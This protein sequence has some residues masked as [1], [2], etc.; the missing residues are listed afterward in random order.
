MELSSSFLF[1]PKPC[2]C[3]PPNYS[4]SPLIRNR[5][6]NF[7]IVA[8]A[9]EPQQQQDFPSGNSPQRLLKE[10]AERK[11]ATSPKKGPPRRFILRPPID[12]NKLAE[13][14]LNSP[15]LCL[16]LFPL[17]SSC[18]PSSRLN[19]ADKLW[20]DEYLL[21]AKQA[22]GYSLEPSETLGDDNP[23]KQF[24][25]LLYLAFQ[26]PSCER[27]KARHVRSGHSRLSFLGQYVLELALTEFFL[28]R[29]PRESPGPMR[30][31]VFGLIGKRSLPKWIKAASLHNLIFTFDDMDKIMRREKEGPVK[32]VFWALFGAIYLCFGMP[33]VYRVLFEVFGMDPDAE[34]CQPKLRRQLED[35]DYVSA[36]FE[37]K[38][39]WQ[40]IVA[41]K[42]PADALFEHPR[43]FR[44]CV[45]PGMHRFRGNIWD[46]DTRPHVMK[47]LGYPLEMTDRIPEITE[48]RNVELGLGL[49]LCFMHPSKF[50][51]EHPRF[52]YERLEYIGQ[53]IQD[54]V[55]AERL[56]MKH[57][58][59]PGLWL[60]EKHRR[61]LMN[62]YCGRYLRAKHLHRVII[63]D[64][65]VQD[66]YEHNRRKRN[67]A[68]TAVQQALHGLSY[69]VYGK[70]DVRRLMFEV[71]DFEQIQPKEVV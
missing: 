57:L 41:Y 43:L 50:K 23:A 6:P 3:P 69:L 20:I 33:E 2:S 64:E 65:K 55:M 5:N 15:Q 18:L 60:Q 19:N 44:A 12:D 13:R 29:Y 42:P 37:G 40:D 21:E 10:L 48:A 26:H 9:L 54:L 4:L 66:T 70:R 16:K 7:R 17:L 68:T 59:A 61:L 39:S 45:P 58:D 34:D 11:K 1:S 53:K 71:F 22:L 35:V 49:Q 28:Q 25:T 30:E 38:L 8:V 63:F 36:E 46:Y 14:F 31:R 67:P 27:T 56:L 62:K 52:C 24:D 51:F 47:T 32:S